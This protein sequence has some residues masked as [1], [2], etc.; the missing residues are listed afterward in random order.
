[1]AIFSTFYVIPFLGLAILSNLHGFNYSL[2]STHTIEYSVLLLL[3][4]ILVWESSQLSSL[5]YKA[6]VTLL[7]VLPVLNIINLSSTNINEGFISSTEKGRGLSSSRFSQAIDYIENDSKNA[8]DIIYF[9]PQGD[10]GDLVL[11]TKIRNM[12]M[13]FAGDNF[14]QLSDFKTS[15]ELNVY[16]VYDKQLIKIPKFVQATRGK[17]QNSISEQTTLIGNI[18]VQKITLQ[19]TLSIT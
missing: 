16:L 15:K 6:F 7:L 8:L 13:H 5:A 11:R 2:Y 3:P 10:M 14:P 18:F 1:M 9:L 4:I 17:F 12:A 19:P